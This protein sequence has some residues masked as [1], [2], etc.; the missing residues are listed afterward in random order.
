MER[1]N[2][3]NNPISSINSIDFRL[4]DVELELSDLNYY[5]DFLEKQIRERQADY[6]SELQKIIKEERLT[7]DD[8]DW[9]IVDVYEH[10]ADFW[11]PWVFRAPFIIS[12]YAVY[13]SS[14][15]KIANLI[16]KQRGI[17]IPINEERKTFNLDRAKECFDDILNFSLYS[18]KTAWERIRTLSTL[19]HAFAH[20]NGRIEMLTDNIKDKISIFERQ[21][22]GISSENG[23]IVLE[24]GFLR[25]TLSMVSHSL[26]DLV[27]RYKQ[28]DNHQKAQAGKPVPPTTKSP[29]P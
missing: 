12:L 9:Q 14:V 8:S 1:E 18:D 22:I 24:E 5:V 6:R 28:W 11:I 27:E 3:L 13:E 10:M 26:N 16:Q 7:P 17:K 21:K 29:P 20:A 4:L 15:T 19:R 23:F 2:I 25:D